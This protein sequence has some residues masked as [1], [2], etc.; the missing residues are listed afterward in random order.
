MSSLISFF[1]FFFGFVLDP[2]KIQ[3]K[4]PRKYAIKY[5]EVISKSRIHKIP[6]INFNI[7]LKIIK[8]FFLLQKQTS[9]QGQDTYLDHGHVVVYATHDDGVKIRR[10]SVCWGG[11]REREHSSVLQTACDV[12]GNRMSLTQITLSEL[13]RYRSCTSSANVR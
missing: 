9:T 13:G 5:Q 11:G 1:F 6:W 3:E 10:G 8:L 12:A 2:K 4:E 7:F